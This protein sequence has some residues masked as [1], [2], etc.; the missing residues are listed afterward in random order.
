MSSDKEI[1]LLH[2]AT[3]DRTTNGT[4]DISSLTAAQ[5]HELEIDTSDYPDLKD[6]IL[7]VPTFES[8]MKLA[9]CYDIIVNIDGS[10]MNWSDTDFT[11]KIVGIIK[12]HN[13]WS[14]VFFVIG[15][16]KQRSD[17]L[18]V[19]PDAIVSWMNSNATEMNTTL[20]Q[21]KDYQ[22]AFLSIPL[23]LATDSVIDSIHSQ[24]NC[25]QV[26]EVNTQSEL[27][28]LKSKGVKLVETDKLLP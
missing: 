21:L 12:K 5:V 20:T 22:N 19:Y 27:N 1:F 24:T 26:Y 14:K 4:G 6:Q 8:V 16:Q 10:K 17:F 25:F 28:R 7:R 3:V 9:S 2:D 13:M 23:S 18:S 15:N 11:S